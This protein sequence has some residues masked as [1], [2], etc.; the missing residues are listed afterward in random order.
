[1]MQCTLCLIKPDVLEKNREKELMNVIIQNGFRICKKKRIRFTVEQAKKFYEVHKEKDHFEDLVRNIAEKDL[2]ALIIS[3]E[4]FVN[5]P[6]DKVITEFR[7]LMGSTFN[8]A[9]NTLRGMFAEKEGESK[10]WRYRNAV[11]GSDSIT[12]FLYEKSIV[13]P[14]IDAF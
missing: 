10:N 13:F 8:A 1:M 2:I 4:V 5:D 14:E 11:H 6:I 9:P 3:K 7:A 12:S